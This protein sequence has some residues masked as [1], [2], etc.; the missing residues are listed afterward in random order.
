MAFDYFTAQKMNFSI[1]NFFSKCDQIRSFLWI[2]SHLLKKF[3]MENFNCLLMENFNCLLPIV[4]LEVRGDFLKQN[5]RRSAELLLWIARCYPNLRLFPIFSIKAPVKL[6]ISFYL[7]FNDLLII[8]K[9]K[10][11]LESEKY[12]SN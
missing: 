5:I 3:L 8:Q 11:K 4:Y 10:N 7:T 1:K 6:N 2:W 12:N 9:R